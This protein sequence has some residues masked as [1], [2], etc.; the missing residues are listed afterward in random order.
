MPSDAGPWYSPPE[1]AA[2]YRKSLD[3]IY[4]AISKGTISAVNTATTGKRRRWAISLQSLER[5]EESRLNTPAPP[6]P[7]R[8]RPVRSAGYI[9]FF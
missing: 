2:R 7:R 4:V 1:V 6:A 9:E 8:R 5:F 3:W